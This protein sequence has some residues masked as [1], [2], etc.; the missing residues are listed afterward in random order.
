MALHSPEYIDGGARADVRVAFALDAEKKELLAHGRATQCAGDA[1]LRGLGVS[2]LLPS[3]FSRSA[4]AS[5]TCVLADALTCLLA[6]AAGLEN[7]FALCR[8]VRATVYVDACSAEAARQLANSGLAQED[9]NALMGA[10][11][12]MGGMS[13]IGGTPVV[14]LRWSPSADKVATL[15]TTVGAEAGAGAVPRGQCAPREET[16][17]GQLCRGIEELAC[18]V[19]VLATQASLLLPFAVSLAVIEH[20]RAEVAEFEI[21]GVR[22]GSVLEHHIGRASELFRKYVRLDNV[23]RADADADAGAGAGAGAEYVKVRH[24]YARWAYCANDDVAESATAPGAAFNEQ[25][26][27]LPG[28][29]GAWKHAV[30]YHR[31]NDRAAQLFGEILYKMGGRWV[32]GSK[33]DTELRNMQHIIGLHVAWVEFRRQQLSPDLVSRYAGTSSPLQ[34][35]EPASRKPGEVMDTHV[36]QQVITCLPLDKWHHPRAV[37]NNTRVPPAAVWL[38][39]EDGVLPDVDANNPRSYSLSASVAMR[40]DVE[41]VV[42]AHMGIDTTGA[43]DEDPYGLSGCG[44]LAE[45]GGSDKGHEGDEGDEG[46]VCALRTN[47]QL[48]ATGRCAATVMREMEALGQGNG[49][50]YAVLKHGTA[51]D[52]ASGDA[53]EGDVTIERALRACATELQEQPKILKELRAEVEELRASRR[54]WSRA[55][56]AP[57][58]RE[59]DLFVAAKFLKTRLRQVFKTKTKAAGTASLTEHICAKLSAPSEAVIVTGDWMPVMCSGQEAPLTKGTVVDLMLHA[60]KLAC[61]AKRTPESVNDATMDDALYSEIANIPIDSASCPRD[62][63]CAGDGLGPLLRLSASAL[64]C[65]ADALHFG[66]GLPKRVP[67]VAV[68]STE[69]PTFVALF[70]VRPGGA[71]WRTDAGALFQTTSLP[72]ILWLK[73]RK[74]SE[75]GTSSISPTSPPYSVITYS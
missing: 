17:V 21:G 16:Y 64:E 3:S 44:E 48:L 69:R 65:V 13:G 10:T 57:P 50:L 52:V 49:A 63:L 60:A 19:S 2:L 26:P 55:A 58:D 20:V 1:P 9:V 30:L 75:T 61:N 56:H 59:S 73:V 15:A 6:H 37:R 33:A 41:G 51:L 67:F 31:R 25:V 72:A 32:A 66:A 54:A 47:G 74:E 29:Q 28:L 36:W 62:V 42:D 45:D 12:G 7:S 5:S 4:S 38:C 43:K 35:S 53:F 18:A 24:G 46:D 40:N 22:E 39:N 71:L 23:E 14:V 8:D 11:G 34:D 27:R 70:Q 68:E